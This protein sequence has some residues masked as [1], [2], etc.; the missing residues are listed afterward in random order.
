MRLLKFRAWDGEKMR[1]SFMIHNETGFPMISAY[2]KTFGFSSNIE[3]DWI[4]TQ[5]TGETDKNGMEIFEGD[6][7]AEY[8][9][10]SH[11]YQYYCE[12]KFFTGLSSSGDMGCMSFQG[13][14]FAWHSLSDIVVGNKFENP[15]L[16]NKCESIDYE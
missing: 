13:S 14:G 16:L 3:K 1:T 11:E 5:F 7:M 2:Q 10:F 8:N 6:I 4:V 12:V 9:E 15:N